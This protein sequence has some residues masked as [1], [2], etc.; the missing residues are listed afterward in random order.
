MIYLKLTFIEKGMETVSNIFLKSDK[1][2]EINEI[3]QVPLVFNY[4]IYNYYLSLLSFSFLNCSPNITKNQTFTFKYL[5]TPFPTQ[6]DPNPDPVEYTEVKTVEAGLYDTSDLIDLLNSYFDMKLV[7]TEN[8]ITYEGQVVTFAINPFNERT[9][10]KFNTDEASK[11]RISRVIIEI[12]EG[13]LLNNDLFRIPVQ[14]INL[15]QGHPEF[16]STNAFRIS[17]YNNVM[18]TSSSIPGLVSLYGNES[19]SDTGTGVKGITTSSALYVISS[20]ASPYSMIEYTAIQPVDFPLNGVP[21]LTNFQFKLVDENNNDLILLPN[22][23]PDF[24]IKLAIK[25]HPKF[26]FSR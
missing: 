4:N 10:I 23:T 11:V 17:T 9:E 7:D 19:D 22:G 12:T 1:S 2:F 16:K 13:S 24:S 15:V 18:L 25:R 3:S 20:V 6:Q 21:N 26:T 8:Q 5:Q 14:T